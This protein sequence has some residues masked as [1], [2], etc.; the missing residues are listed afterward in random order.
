MARQIRINGR[1]W[2]E[3]YKDES[4]WKSGGH[5]WW[6]ED[7][8]FSVNGEDAIDGDLESP[9]D[10]DILTFHSGVLY[11]DSWGKSKCLASEIRKWLKAKA[12][13]N[14]IAEVNKNRL[15]EFKALM[16]LHKFKILA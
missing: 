2:K 1:D 15:D 8:G 12:H 5:E 10:M 3:F 7:E 6:H 9:S 4:V 16:K 11:C 14:L 13:V